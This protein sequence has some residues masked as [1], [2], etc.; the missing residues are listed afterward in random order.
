MR[1]RAP[2]LRAAALAC[3]LAALCLGAAS[4]QPPRTPANK[5]YYVGTLTARGATAAP[6]LLDLSLWDDG[7]AF[8]RL[9]L[10]GRGE[11]L[12]GTGRLEESTDLR[13]ALRRADPDEDPWWAAALARAAS[14]GEAAP[15]REGEVVAVLTAD[16]DYGWEDEGRVLNGVLRRASGEPATLTA[17]RLASAA[18]WSFDMGRVSSAAVLPRFPGRD[19]LNRWLVDGALPTARGFADEGLATLD[20]GALGWG[21]WREER[22]DVAGA[23]GPY[24]SL[25]STTDD[26]TGGAHPNSFT[27]SY[28]LA[29]DGDEVT[30]LGLADLFAGDG[31]LAELS[32]LVLD[33][34]A[35]QGAMWVTQGEVEALAADDLA[36][37]TL[38]AAGLTFHFSPY[39][40]GPYVQ[41]SFRVTVPYDA[42][43][44]LA[45]PDGPLAS[46]A[47]G[48][49]P[50][51]GGG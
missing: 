5:D 31:W 26:Y 34:L 35:E 47:R 37:F 29:V 27:G 7:F 19:A 10:L 15:E 43:A 32:A 6:V 3:T 30:V 17:T 28:L 45:A 38:D 2:Y 39:Q 20:D 50:A 12:F 13:L 4:A 44:H 33:G 41:G 8:A 23:S 1:V 24:L 42:L 51:L 40:M 46:F 16:R 11:V 18:R 22:V 14:A 48:D 36:A 21:W 49:E 9:Q 25:L